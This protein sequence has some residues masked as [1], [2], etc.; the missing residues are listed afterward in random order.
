MMILVCVKVCSCSAGWLSGCLATQTLTNVYGIGMR[1]WWWWWQATRRPYE[2]ARVPFSTEHTRTRVVVE[3]DTTMAP[4]EHA[5][6]AAVGRRLFS[7]TSALS[8]VNNVSLIGVM[9]WRYGGG[10]ER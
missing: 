5:Y 6:G 10:C 1:R 9:R 2:C 8:I 4:C 7:Y 3:R